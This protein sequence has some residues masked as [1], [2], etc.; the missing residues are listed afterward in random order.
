[1]I[2]TVTTTVT[3]IAMLSMG[4]TLGAL[5]SIVLILMLAL[6]EVASADS[7]RGLQLLAKSLSVGI[8]P[9]L[10]SFALIVL[11]KILEVLS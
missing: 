10:A 11:F 9:L 4:A 5:A 3:T 2:S 7:R 6:K 1:M 8:A